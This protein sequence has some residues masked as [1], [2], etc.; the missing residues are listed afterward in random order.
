MPKKSLKKLAGC[1]VIEVLCALGAQ[2]AGYDYSAGY[3]SVG[4]VKALALEDRHGQ[5]AVI[6]AAAFSVP[7]SVADMIAAQAIKAYK[8]DRASLMI[9]SVASGDPVPQD[10]NTA[11]GAALGKLQQ[12]YLVYGNGRLT[13][14]LS[15]GHCVAGLTAEAALGPCTNAA[16]DTLGGVIR[17]ALRVVDLSHGLETRD[18]TP[19]S[20][21]VQAIAIGPVVILAVPENYARPGRRMILAVSPAIENDQRVNQAIGEL[22]VRVGGRP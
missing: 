2:A 14:S 19:R 4:Q 7:L 16:G 9:Y 21:A 11:I 15:D 12:I 10:A 3:A 18:T 22:F 8:L 6:V 20:V 1:I 5:R 17:S 13:A